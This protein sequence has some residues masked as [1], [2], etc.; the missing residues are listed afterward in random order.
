ME[1]KLKKAQASSKSTIRLKKDARDREKNMFKMRKDMVE[2]KAEKE[3]LEALVRDLRATN[4]RQFSRTIPIGQPIK[5]LTAKSTLVNSS[6]DQEDL[7]KLTL[8]KEA[9]TD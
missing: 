7:K 1:R 2:M 9:V 5:V 3:S 8:E 6:F 4:T